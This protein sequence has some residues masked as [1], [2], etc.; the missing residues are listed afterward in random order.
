VLDQL[1]LLAPL[2]KMVNPVQLAK[3]ELPGQRE[4]PEKL[5]PLVRPA[6]KVLLAPPER[7]GKPA[8]PELKVFLV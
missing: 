5:A 8:P 4:T 3:P 1:V 2:G 6:S 7:R